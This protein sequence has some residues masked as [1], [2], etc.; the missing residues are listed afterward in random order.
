MAL[1]F[2]KLNFSTSFNPTSGFPIDARTY[3]ESF[4]LAQ[5]AAATAEAA[6]SSNTVYYYGQILTV[7]EDNSVAAYQITADKTLVKLAETTAS[8]DLEADVIALQGKVTALETAVNTTI[9]ATY[10]TIETVNGINARVNTA[11]GEIDTLQT[12]VDAVEANVGT[13]QTTVSGINTRLNTAET[14]LSG[15]EDGAEVNILE[16]V[17]VQTTA[18]GGYTPLQINDKIAQLDLSSYALK[19]DIST[20]FNYKGTVDTYANL[21]SSDQVTG[22]VYIVTNGEGAEDNQEYV[23]DGTAWEAL[24]TTIDLSGYATTASVTQAISTATNDMA[25][26]TWVTGT[27]LTPYATTANVTSAIESATDDMATQTWVTTTIGEEL[28]DYVTVANLTS[29]LAT[30][31][32]ASTVTAL[33]GNVTAIES[34]ITSINAS[35]ANKVEADDV[36]TAIAEATIEASKINGAVANAQYATQA[37]SLVNAI[38][39]NVAGTTHTLIEGG[40]VAINATTLGALTAIPV[41]TNDAL[42]GIRTGFVSANGNYAV[43]LDANNAAYVA[44]PVPD[45]PAYTGTGAVNV[46]ANGNDFVVSIVTGGIVGDMIAANTITSDK[47]ASV[48]TDAL[49]QGSEELILN[50]GSAS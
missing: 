43:Q 44:V 30:K 16:G 4:E 21:P 41:A 8:G 48:S 32:D 38:S 40:E 9:P 28:A 31:A 35:L 47:I 25:T 11:E 27:A 45:V 19:S 3:F 34:N 18:G 15:I 12:D 46:A 23:W 13:I 14:K 50:G 29:N 37:G 42:G 6:G 33:Q 7:Y 24:G 26:Q 39:L 17:S 20:V 10:A 22:D 1:D 49:V 36:A 2:G 5:A